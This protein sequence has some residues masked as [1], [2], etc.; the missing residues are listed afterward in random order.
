MRAGTKVAH[1]HGY[2][3]FPGRGRS[4][5]GATHG[6]RRTTPTSTARATSSDVGSAG[7]VVDSDAEHDG[8]CRGEGN[9]S[10]GSI[11]TR[12]NQKQ[13]DRLQQ[14][15]AEPVVRLQQK[16]GTDAYNILA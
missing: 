13:K 14:T 8:T 7:C 1:V 5:N 10:A 15:G 6:S 3:N 2:M 4:D 16:L 9:G 12:R 11:P